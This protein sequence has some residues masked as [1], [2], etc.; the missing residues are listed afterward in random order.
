MLSA[1]VL[2]LVS[3]IVLALSG[4]QSFAEESATIKAFSAW[5]GRGQAFQTGLEEATFVGSFSG[6]VYVET[7]EGPLDAGF[8]TCPALVTINLNDGTQFGEGRCTIVAKDGDRVFGEIECEGI[9]LV[10]CNGNF[11]LTGGTGRFTGITGGGP[12]LI[13]SGLKEVMT[14]PGNVVRESAS[15]ILIWQERSYQSP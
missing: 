4:H 1:F 6:V 7:Q 15:G 9:H 14:L 11:A 8:M 2:S 5:Q 12:I 10:G 3:A 13:R